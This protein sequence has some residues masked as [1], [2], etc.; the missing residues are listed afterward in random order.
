[1]TSIIVLGCRP[2]D[3]GRAVTGWSPITLDKESSLVIAIDQDGYVKAIQDNGYDGVNTSWKYPASKDD[4]LIGSFFPAVIN[5]TSVLVTGANGHVYSLNKSNGSLSDGGWKAPETLGVELPRIYSGVAIDQENKVGFIATE[6]GVL[7]GYDLANGKPLNW[8]FNIDSP[9]WGTPAVEQ[10]RVYFGAHDKNFYSVDTS[11]GLV[12]WSY[13]TSGAIVSQPVISEDIILFGSFDRNL[14]AIDKTSGA[15]RWTF[16]GSNWFWAP[17]TISGTT[18]YAASMNGELY[19]IDHNGNSLWEYKH[20]EPIVSPPLITNSGIVIVSID[21]KLTLLD[22]TPQDIGEAREKS[23]LE[24]GDTGVKSPMM[25]DEEYIYVSSQKD[26]L[27]KL[28]V[29]S[30]GFNQIWCYDL[31]EDQLCE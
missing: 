30:S 27:R 8:S 16:E 23:T 31:E 12:D 24:L 4:R 1:M 25:H 10:G 5:D 28:R 13:E 20:K 14:Y 9:I 6:N 26:R 18:I 11:T 29:S 3:L 19:A 22:A 2:G 7:Q 21:G 17:P 15:L